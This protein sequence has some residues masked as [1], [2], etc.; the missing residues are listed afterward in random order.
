MPIFPT[1][2]FA[3]LSVL[4][5]YISLAVATNA[6]DAL[7]RGCLQ[8]ISKYTFECDKKYAKLKNSRVSGCQCWSDEFV[9]TYYD[10]ISRAENGNTKRSLNSLVQACS[11]VRPNISQQVV[12]DTYK[13]ATQ[14][15]YWIPI[16]NITDKKATLYSPVKFKQSQIDLAFRSWA[17][18]FY[19]GKYA[20][21]L[22]G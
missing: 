7:Y 17:A 14:G 19:S 5:L 9:A 13:N 2:K 11:A 21:Q 10:C 15:D 22:Y 8:M 18:S 6:G 12:L 16:K 4:A 1:M 3:L 20:G